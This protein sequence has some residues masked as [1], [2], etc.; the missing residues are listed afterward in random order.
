LS[1]GGG[2]TGAPRGQ[3]MHSGGFVQGPIGSEQFVIAQAGEYVVP[4]GGNMPGDG[5]NVVVN[6]Q[7]SVMTERD[8]VQAVREGL[9]R[10]ERRNGAAVIR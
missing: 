10:T 2:G 9:I 6:V 5:V 8:L 1:K 4:L 3:V 7:G